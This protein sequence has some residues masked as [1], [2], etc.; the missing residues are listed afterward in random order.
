MGTYFDLLISARKRVF[1]QLP[2]G[3]GSRLD[4]SALVVNYEEI[5]RVLRMQ[6]AKLAEWL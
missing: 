3:R 5:I 1:F 4:S 2:F 6:S